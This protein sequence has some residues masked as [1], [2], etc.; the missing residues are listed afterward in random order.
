MEYEKLCFDINKHNT[1]VYNEAFDA[2]LNLKGL[3][4]SSKY[5]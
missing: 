1:G 4:T 3:N 2:V 5:T